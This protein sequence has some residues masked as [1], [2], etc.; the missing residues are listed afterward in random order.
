MKQFF[1]ALVLTLAA[2]ASLLILYD[3]LRAWPD[4]PTQAIE[5]RLSAL[6]AKIS[7]P[8]PPEQAGTGSD[9]RPADNSD[10]MGLY[11]TLNERVADV[12]GMVF[13]AERNL[14]A[15][16]RGVYER[17]LSKLEQ[18]TVAAAPMM[19]PAAA[20]REF[21]SKL[22]EMG[23]KVVEEEGMVE[24]KGAVGRPTQTLELMGIAPGGRA[25]ETLLVLDATPRALKLAL[26]DLGVKEVPDPDPT[27]GRFIENADGVYIYVMWDA[28]KKPRRAEDMIFNA[29]TRDTMQRTKWIFTASRFYT[30]TRTWERHFAA[31]LHKNIISI[32]ANYSTDCILACPLEDAAN[33]QIWGPDDV[34]CPDPGT[35]VRVMFCLKPNPVWDKI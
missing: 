2:G 10:L 16:L 34:G 9:A 15:D 13:D 12:E 19:P 31:D 18:L 22:L 33:E 11:K 4:S 17:L 27:T 7:K 20:K 35:K 21:R 3:R 1:L 28:L 32:T 25:H 29:K 30:D 24:V 5:Q 8:V 6:E 14:R 23:V 26:E